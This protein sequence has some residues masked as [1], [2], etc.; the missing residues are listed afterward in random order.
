[1]HRGTCAQ[2]C[3]HTFGSSCNCDRGGRLTL[4]DVDLMGSQHGATLHLRDR[5]PT[6]RISATIIPYDVTIL[7]TAN[8]G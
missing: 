1:M 8:S 2:T 5:V 3:T 7:V 6:C 4:K